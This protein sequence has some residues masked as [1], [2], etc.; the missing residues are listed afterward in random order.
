M[1]SLG[2]NMY[3][4]DLIERQIAADRRRGFRVD[5]DNNSQRV[6]QLEKDL[7]GIMGEIGEF[8]NALKK[9]RLAMEHSAYDGPSLTE[10]APNL[11]EELADAFIY[12]MRLSVVLGGDLESDLLE[13]MNKN[14][15]K[16]GHL[17]R[18]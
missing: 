6:V 2:V 18:K 3:L 5:F 14:D 10:V 4:S 13:K 15:R 16:Y 9:V 7:V 11:R 12:L 8:A 17:E 1:P